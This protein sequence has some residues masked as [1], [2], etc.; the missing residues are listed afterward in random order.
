MATRRPLIASLGIGAIDLRRIKVP[1]SGLTVLAAA[2]LGWVLIPIA[3][4]AGIPPDV[5]V[6]LGV[7]VGGLAAWTKRRGIRRL[8]ERLTE[9]RVE[10]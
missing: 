8:A 2:L 1:S 4:K 3:L 10:S 5:P 7:I 6:G 9:R